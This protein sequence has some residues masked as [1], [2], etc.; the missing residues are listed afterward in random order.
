MSKST[1]LPPVPNSQPAAQAV[2]ADVEV[3]EEI[4]AFQS[5]LKTKILYV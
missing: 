5:L 2:E 3:D 4:L 1:L